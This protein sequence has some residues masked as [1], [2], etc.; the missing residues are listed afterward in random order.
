MVKSLKIMIVDDSSLSQTRLTAVLESIGHQVVMVASNGAEAVDAYEKVMPDMVTM[1]ITMPGMDG[2][3]ATRRLLGKHPAAKI[4][5]VTSHAEREMLF[6]A[7]GAGAKGYIL[8]PFQNDKLREAID[9]MMQ[10]Q[11]PKA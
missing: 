9:R 8:K 4:M 11:A 3:V 7:L 10:A 6:Q 5:M 1:D 2:I